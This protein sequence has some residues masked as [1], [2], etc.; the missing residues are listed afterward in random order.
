MNEPR[1][2]GYCDITDPECIGG[3]DAIACDR[4]KPCRVFKLYL[5]DNGLAA[6]RYLSE[7]FAEGEVVAKPKYTDGQWENFLAGCERKYS[8]KTTPKAAKKRRRALTSTEKVRA[9]LGE[10]GNVKPL[11]T[12]SAKP[13]RRY[14]RRE[15]VAR[16]HERLWELTEHF[17]V[18]L[19][20][21]TGLILSDRKAAAVPGRLYF[22]NKWTT[23]GYVSLYIRTRTRHDR[24][25]VAVYPKP[26]VAG[27]M[28][29]LP[30]T[31]AEVKKALRKVD[32]RKFKFAVRHPKSPQVQSVIVE[33]G[34]A[35]GAILAE[36]V[37]KLADREWLKAGTVPSTG[38]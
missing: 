9:L 36:A 23:A 32:R 29:H 35:K 27:L 6:E 26:T 34:L 2:F 31:E 20:D 21:A 4:L 33:I 24:L 37:A 13:V 16:M 38:F 3:E 14:Q 19:L 8:R 7:S 28:I 15:N 17:Y 12:T 22:S 30:F 1:C 5:D 25:V 11:R 18:G 10:G